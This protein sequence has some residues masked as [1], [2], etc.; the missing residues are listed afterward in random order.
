MTA[1]YTTASGLHINNLS[2]RLRL[3]E[4]FPA[5]GQHQCGIGRLCDEMDGEQSI[6]GIEC[7]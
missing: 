6:S 4:V 1:G 2:R 5:S 7:A 3:G